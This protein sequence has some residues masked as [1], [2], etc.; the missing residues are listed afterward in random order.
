MSLLDILR[1]G[2]AIIDSS[3]KA[4]QST[5]LYEQY[6]GTDA[7]GTDIWVPAVAMLAIVDWRESQTKTQAGEMVLSHTTLTFV[8]VNAMV[9]ATGGK[10]ISTQDRITLPD[11]TTGP[12]TRLAG[13]IDAGTTEP[14]ATEVHIGM[15]SGTIR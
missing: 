6:G 11:G 14:V 10:G 12:I 4:L 2:V 5:I 9:A 1:S 13:F 7:Y 8:D 15:G 3:T